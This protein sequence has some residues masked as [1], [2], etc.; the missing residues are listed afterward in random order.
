MEEKKYNFYFFVEVLTRSGASFDKFDCTLGNREQT[1][2]L[3]H[4][5]D[6]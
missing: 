1:N 4:W 2:M 6:L 5:L 3:S